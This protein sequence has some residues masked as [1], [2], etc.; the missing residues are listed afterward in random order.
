MHLFQDVKTCLEN[1][2]LL[3][4]MLNKYGIRAKRNLYSTI[5][6]FDKPKD[7]WLIDRWHL[8]CVGSTSHAVVM[9]HTT[10]LDIE[11]F[12]SEMGHCHRLQH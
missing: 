8:A 7:K 12:A 5:V 1:A 10:K 11:K 2:E 4:Q 6:V 9:P 3:N